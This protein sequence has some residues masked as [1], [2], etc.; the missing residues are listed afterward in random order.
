VVEGLRAY[1][2][3]LDAD[4]SG[5]LSISEFKA[6]EVLKLGITLPDVD[7]VKADIFAKLDADEDKRISWAEF[8][9]GLLERSADLCFDSRVS[10][11]RKLY[12][13]GAYTGARSATELVASL[14]QHE[15]RRDARRACPSS[16]SCSSL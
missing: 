14:E 15:V 3:S 13:E 2:D 9:A 4:H 8:K 6:T 11:Y 5:Y 7:F 1:F 12:G 10:L 16:R